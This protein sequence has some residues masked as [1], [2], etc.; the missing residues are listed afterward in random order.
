MR[1][2]CLALTGRSAATPFTTAG[3]ASS[4]ISVTATPEPT[5]TTTTSTTWITAGCLRA[6]KPMELS[7]PINSTIIQCTIQQPGIPAPAITTMTGSIHLAYQAAVTMACISTTT[8][9]MET[10]ESVRPD[11]YTL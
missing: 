4:K 3:G 9:S 10:G 5:S 2:R 1:S 8:T 11:L 7:V 6:Q